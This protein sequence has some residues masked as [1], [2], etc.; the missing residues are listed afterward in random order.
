MLEGADACAAGVKVTLKGDGE[1]CETRSGV[2]G[3]F[4][5]EKLPRGRTYRVTVA[6]EG[7]ATLSCEVRT[8]TDVDLGQV[9]LAKA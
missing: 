1:T 3:D 5:F 6:H 4:A 8:H 9:V 2:F 7:Y